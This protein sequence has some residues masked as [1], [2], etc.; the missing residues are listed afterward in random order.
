MRQ[1]GSARRCTPSA[2]RSA[3][4]SRER[5]PVQLVAPP[6]G[7]D[8]KAQLS[9]AHPVRSGVQRNPGNA[10]PCDWLHP[11]ADAMTSPNPDMHARAP[12][13][14]PV[15]DRRLVNSADVMNS[16]SNNAKSER[17]CD[18]CTTVRHRKN[19]KSKQKHSVRNSG[20]LES[21]TGSGSISFSPDSS[22]IV[23]FSSITI[24]ILILM[25]VY[26]LVS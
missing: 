8:N 20:I 9:V 1:Q 17:S 22:H 3:T 2:I 26:G 21:F 14:T 19:I 6:C 15:R 24:R 4:K 7:C 5:T 11:R 12:H 25:I 13:G 23:R 10:P 16:N 18:R